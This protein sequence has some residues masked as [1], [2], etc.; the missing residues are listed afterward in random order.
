MSDQTMTL[1]ILAA[2]VADG[3]LTEERIDE[4]Y[5]RIMALKAKWER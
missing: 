3:R 1:L 5:R 4:S 2:A